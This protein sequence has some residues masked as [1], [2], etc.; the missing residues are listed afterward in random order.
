M[1]SLREEPFC[2]YV[3]IIYG[4]IRVRETSIEHMARTS[5]KTNSKY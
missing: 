3:L 4:K 2:D 1:C 5:F